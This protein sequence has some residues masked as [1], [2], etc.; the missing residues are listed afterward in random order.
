MFTQKGGLRIANGYTPKAAF[1][2]F[3]SNSYIEVLT[4]SGSGGIL[5]KS[6]LKPG[7]LSPYI[8]SRSNNN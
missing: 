3:I 5:F 8:S 2:Y 4:Y 1:D 7:Y 6:E